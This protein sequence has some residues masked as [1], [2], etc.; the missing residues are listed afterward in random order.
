M[1]D[2]TDDK[3]RRQFGLIL[4]LISNRFGLLKEEIFQ[5][6]PEYHQQ[7]DAFDDSKLDSLERK[8]ERDKDDIRELG[9]VI[10]AFSVEHS[11]GGGQETRY[12]IVGENY[13]FP[14]DVSFSQAEMTLLRLAA[15]AWRDGSLSLDSRHALTKLRSLGVPANEPLIGL[16]PRISTQNPVFEALKGV[17]DISG[18]ASFLYLKPGETQA[19][20]R[21]A[22]PLALVYRRGLWYMLA[23]DT[24]ADAQRTFLLSRIVSIPKRHGSTIFDGGS[25]NHTKQLETELD[26]LE[27]SHQARIWVEPGS[28]AFVRL[29]STYASPNEESVIDVNFSD[30]DLLADELTEFAAAVK[31]ITPLELSDALSSRFATLSRAHGGVK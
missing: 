3:V 17:L 20:L 7:Y 28:D 10:D 16:A 31:V 26:E 25:Q 24:E 19:R 9:V 13:D 11:W 1:A 2:E 15:E 4:T 27:Q 5:S 21:K 29:S 22:A 18:V 14:D 8:F 12:R 30:I 6:V 23:H